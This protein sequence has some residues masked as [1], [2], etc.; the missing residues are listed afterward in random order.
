MGSTFYQAFKL[1]NRIWRSM[2]GR[3][4]VT[5]IG[6]GFA[7]PNK[8]AKGAAIILYTDKKMSSAKKSGLYEVTGKWTKASSVP[9]R[10]YMTGQFKESSVSPTQSGP[11]ERWRPIP[12][13]VS[14]GTTVPT[15]A[16][17]TGGL[18][19][20]KNNTLFILSNAHVLVPDNTT[21]FHNTIQP[22]PADGGRTAD[23]IG[24]AFQFVPRRTTSANF[25]DSAIAVANSNSLLNPRYLINDRGSLITVPGHLLSYQVGMTFK[26]MGKTSGFGRGV[27]EAIGVERTVTG[28]L[29]TLLYRD[30]TVV[31]FTENRS[32][33]GDSG[34]VWLNDSSDRLNNYAAAVHFASPSD[35][36]RS[37]CYPIERAM[38]SY[39][40]LVAIPAGSTGRFKAG[41]VGGRAPR[42]N[43]AYVRPLT[44]KQLSLTTPVLNVRR[45]K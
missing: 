7:D 26:K 36:S 24:R 9:F 22:S 44:R 25:Q 14:V 37:I 18:I 20:I 2:L 10:V 35:G 28:N 41:A 11:R 8:P 15:S 33:P 12:G 16:G 1:K 40:T 38:R 45:K 21:E 30:Q 5:G 39:G 27:V 32:L 43:Y 17:G 19:V 42:N 13:G 31:R 6:V 29:G 3:P 4:G 34:S 23:Q